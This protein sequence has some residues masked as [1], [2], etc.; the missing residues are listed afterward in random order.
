MLDIQQSVE[1]TQDD[2]SKDD[3]IIPTINFDDEKDNLLMN[4]NTPSL[5]LV[6]NTGSKSQYDSNPVVDNPPSQIHQQ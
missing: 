4:G 2:H 3:M 6:Y 1:I 5:E